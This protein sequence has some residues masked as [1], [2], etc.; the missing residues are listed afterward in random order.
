MP[1]GRG[2]QHNNRSAKELRVGFRDDPN[3]KGEEIEQVDDLLSRYTH[4]KKKTE[5]L[6]QS[7]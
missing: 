1:Q 7:L 6:A 4:E 5:R 3:A 2:A